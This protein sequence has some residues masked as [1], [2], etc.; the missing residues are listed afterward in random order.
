[1]GN[2]GAV[3]HL[4]DKG[5]CIPPYSVTFGIEDEFFGLDSSSAVNALRSN[6]LDA[7]DYGYHDDSIAEWRIVEDGSVTKEGLE[8]CSPILRPKDK[9]KVRLAVETLSA[10]GAEI[11]ASAGLHVHHGTAGFTIPE[12]AD[13]VSHYALF[14]PVLNRLV[15]ESRLKARSDGSFFAVPLTGWGQLRERILRYGTLQDLRREAWNFSR[16]KTVNMQAMG[17]H[18]TIEY[19]QHHATMS[20]MKA[21]RWM[22]LTQLLHFSGKTRTLDQTLRKLGGVTIE[23]LDASEMVGVLGGDLGLATYWGNREKML[24]TGGDGDDCA[25]NTSS[26]NEEDYCSFCAE[27][28]HFERPDCYWCTI[29]EDNGHITDDCL[30]CSECGMWDECECEER[31]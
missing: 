19:R 5:W 17:D 10:R 27:Y 24:K 21:L 28:G 8:L 2:E 16:Y 18:S 4:Q 23:S 12:I 29:C 1:M 20:G 7:V 22:E 9:G 30:R 26:E 13:S 6:G 3:E 31:S 14:Q 15:T 11:D 25:A